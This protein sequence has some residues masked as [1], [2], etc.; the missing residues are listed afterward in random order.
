MLCPAGK[1]QDSGHRCRKRQP[2]LPTG[3]SCCNRLSCHWKGVIALVQSRQAV[4]KFC[5]TP[6]QVLLTAHCASQQC[7]AAFGVN[8]CTISSHGDRYNLYLA[9]THLYISATSIYLETRLYIQPWK[10][11]WASHLHRLSGAYS[12]LAQGLAYVPT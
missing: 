6:R 11:S 7:I 2:L 10:L 4:D 5:F 9:D 1:L 3:A 8:V 12:Q